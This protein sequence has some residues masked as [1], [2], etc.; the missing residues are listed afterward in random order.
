MGDFMMAPLGEQG[1]KEL[2]ELVF[3]EESAEDWVVLEREMGVFF[4]LDNLLHRA[5]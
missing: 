1:V 3:L 5:S 2:E 4:R